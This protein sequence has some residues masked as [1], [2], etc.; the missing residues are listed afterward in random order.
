LHI[1]DFPTKTKESD[2]LSKSLK[3]AGFTFVGSTTIYAFMQA[4]GL[5]DDHMVS[6]WKRKEEMG[7]L[8][9]E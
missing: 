9:D 4:V 1:T 8:R 3:K 6:C 7:E 5:V 2:A